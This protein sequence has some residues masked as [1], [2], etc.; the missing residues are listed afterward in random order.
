[1]AGPC[2]QRPHPRLPQAWGWRATACVPLP[3]ISSRTGPHCARRRALYCH[4]LEGAGRGA[5]NA[6]AYHALMVRRGY[7]VAYNA[8]GAGGAKAH[9][10]SRSGVPWAGLQPNEVA[11]HSA[12]VR[13]YVVA[14]NGVGASGAT[15]TH[16]RALALR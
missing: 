4:S 6:V 1:M 16:S 15:F 5:P 11:Y 2:A 7:V 3:L 14:Y 8:V 12:M 13:E 10:P 9:A